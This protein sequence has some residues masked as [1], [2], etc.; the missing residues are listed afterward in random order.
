MTSSNMCGKCEYHSE[1]EEELKEHIM[2]VHV[3]FCSVFNFQTESKTRFDAHIK[4]DHTNRCTNCDFETQSEEDLNMHV[5]NEHKF[6][7][8]K[9]HHTSKNN[10]KHT[11]HTCKVYIQNPTYKNF[12][13]KEWLN[14]NGCNAIYC[15]ELQEDVIWSHSTG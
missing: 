4:K 11:N 9:C 6:S 15:S 10:T 12:Y 5:Y 3:L 1:D 14:G 13:T 8:T 2:L 7:C